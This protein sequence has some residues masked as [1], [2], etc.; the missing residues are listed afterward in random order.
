MNHWAA[1]LADLSPT[2]QRAIARAQRISLPRGCD[3]PTRMAR[4]RMALCRARTVRETFFGLPAEA[5]A[6][7]W[8]LRDCPRG[9]AL[10][11]LAQRYGPIRPLH[12]L[13]SDPHPRSLSERLLLLGW[14][15]PRPATHRHPER[16]LLPPELRRWLPTPLPL[17]DHG[18]APLSPYPPVL[19]A[20]VA[21]LV[22]SA[23]TPLPVRSDGI[24]PPAV[25]KRLLPRLTPL[26][27]PEGLALLRWLCPL[28]CELQLLLPHGETVVP[29][30]AAQPFLDLPPTRQL[31]RLT[32]AWCNTPRPD[33]LICA[34]LLTADG[35]LWPSLRRRLL[36]WAEALPVGQLLAPAELYPALTTAFGPL[37]DAT[38]HALRT[39]RRSPWGT[40]RAMAV[41]QVALTGPLT[42]L[43]VVAWTP[44][45]TGVAPHCFAT[46]RAVLD[47]EPAPHDPRMP[48][49]DTQALGSDAHWTYAPNGRLRV[50][51]AAVGADL[52]AL[53]PFATWEAADAEALTLCFA[54]R[55]LTRARGREQN[56]QR[57]MV[58]LE[59]HAGSVPPAWMPTL[60]M[61]PAGLRLVPMTVVLCADPTLLH[62]LGQDRSVRRAVDAT[63]APG[64]ALVAP[65]HTEAFVRAAERRGVAV[66]QAAAP[67]V[68]APTELT[69]AECA[70]LAALCAQARQP[71]TVALPVVADA[72]LAALEDRLRARLAP[73]FRPPR[74]QHSPASA[75]PV[76][77]AP[78]PHDCLATVAVG[79]RPALAL[80]LIRTALRR[81]H[82]LELV[83][84]PR[85]GAPG[86]RTVIPTRLEQHGAHWYLY[87]FCLVARADRVFR[88]DRIMAL[89]DLPLRA[90]RAFAATPAAEALPPPRPRNRRPQPPRE[91]PGAP[92][93]IMRVWLEP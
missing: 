18:V 27:A 80:A 48:T 88:L 17:L 15:L 1:W 20:L 51:Y 30:P 16:W 66:E 85:D 19:R 54:V 23:E 3:A 7:L 71:T 91:P 29:G 70:S 26:P 89:A 62:D 8:A 75:V 93:P 61:N 47:S 4:L 35:L 37:A 32:A 55:S 21:V 87:A 68:P 41:W 64:V 73:A 90:V 74:V 22:A 40:E 13:R 39:V 46:G 76:A 72:V 24:P 57:C 28:L 9:L 53:T 12:E 6:A 42:W 34:Q 45:P 83:Y 82:A 58:L 2:L 86:V 81:R 92:T 38:T 77:V 36:A 59:R 49:Q 43:G 25:L 33:T 50:P 63:L 11:T 52:L 65:A 56:L 31:Q 5:Q 79:E 67:A 44:E 14:L 84:E 10:A 78:L 69:V 60:T